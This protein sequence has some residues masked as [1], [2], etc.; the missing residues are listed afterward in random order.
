M[1]TH[2]LFSVTK[3][4]IDSL[5]LPIEGMLSLHHE[6][7]SSEE[8]LLIRETKLYIVLLTVYETGRHPFR[9]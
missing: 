1:E 9:R 4:R 7:V 5:C 3:L 6:L 8:F 2:I